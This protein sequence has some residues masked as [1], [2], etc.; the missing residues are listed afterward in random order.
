MSTVVSQGRPEVRFAVVVMGV[1]G[2]GKTTFGRALAQARGLPFFDGDEFHSTEA[3]AKMSAGIA[4]SDGDRAPWLARIG[5]R[6]GDE[7]A[8]PQGAVIACSALRRSYRDRL[9]AF[10]GPE[11]RFVFLDGDKPL[12]LRRVAERRDHYM[13]ASLVDSQFATLEPP[14]GEDDVITLSADASLAEAVQEALRRLAAIDEK[15]APRGTTP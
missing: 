4:L 5:A 12:M 6:L 10:V 11:L 7:R 14:A 1:A 8:L 2:C 9:R 13:P 3:R 15:R